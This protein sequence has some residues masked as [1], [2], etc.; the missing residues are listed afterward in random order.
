MEKTKINGFQKKIIGRAL[1][2]VYRLTDWEEAF[3]Q[4]IQ[5][6]GSYA[7][8]SEN[9]NSMINKIGNKLR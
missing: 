9:Q 7:L 6:G 2:Q 5:G 8:I 3:C 4:S 1:E